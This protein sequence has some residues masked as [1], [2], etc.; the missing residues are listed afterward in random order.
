M[1]KNSFP[2]LIQYALPH[3][4][5]SA[6][7]GRI[8]N[9]RIPWLKN[10]LI[11]IFIRHYGVDMRDARE[12]DPHQYP[13]F[14][15]FFTRCLKPE[16]RPVVQDAKA[17]ACPV[18]GTVSQAGVIAS[19]KLFQAK[20]FSYSLQNLL[21]GCAERAAPFL[22]GRFATLYLAPK[23]YHRVHMPLAGRL[24]E[25]VYV[26]GRLFSVNSATTE[27]VDNLFAR[28]E[29]VI[30]LF[31]TAIGPMAVILVGAMIVGSINTVWAGAINAAQRRQLKV[32]QYQ[33]QIIELDRG[34]DMGHFCLGSTVI[35]LFAANRMQWLPGIQPGQSLRMGSAIGT[36]AM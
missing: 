26:P 11:D 19:D 32:Q 33:Q 8:A 9:C 35:L 22:D 31:D 7:V 27:R 1:S 14:N 3:Q 36:S 16:A 5:L 15:S 13:T 23:D 12:T 18:D 24:R 2:T 6:L 34:T 4:A 20:G 17:I 10:R 29:R 28:N 21:G 30:A 25:M